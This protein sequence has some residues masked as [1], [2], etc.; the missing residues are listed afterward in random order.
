MQEE[1][2]E[3]LILIYSKYSS[4]CQRI[5][6]VL[7][8]NPLHYI[9]LLCIDNTKARQQL[10]ESKKLSVHTVPCIL[11]VYKN[12]IEKFEGPN[13][14]EWVLSQIVNNLDTTQTELM[15]T[16]HNPET[17]IPPSSQHNNPYS[18]TN[19]QGAATPTATIPQQTNEPLTD[20]STS[21]SVLDITDEAP[22][23]PPQPQYK[24]NK[25]I[26]E[27]AAEMAGERDKMNPQNPNSG[28]QG[29]GL[30]ARPL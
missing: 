24:T 10:M 6:Q 16:P 2:P 12:K 8:S 3:Y 22:P 26:T 28:F 15:Y 7:S 29:D 17:M 27:I 11:L 20:G 23:P 13:V 21:L 19:S 18:D 1:N 4:Q 14:T 30:G 9:R 25:S 5:V